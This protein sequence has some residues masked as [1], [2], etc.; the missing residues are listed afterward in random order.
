MVGHCQAISRSSLLARNMAGTL[1]SRYVVLLMAFSH[2]YRL[3]CTPT[4]MH[5]NT[6]MLVILVIYTYF[7]SPLALQLCALKK[8]TSCSSYEYKYALNEQKILHNLYSLKWQ[9]NHGRG[10]E[11][12]PHLLN[13]GEE[14]RLYVRRCSEHN[15][16]SHLFH[17]RQPMVLQNNQLVS[18]I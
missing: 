2:I 6:F 17:E 12:D 18:E 16:V 14:G 7:L 8:F 4:L 10:I 9:T 15:Q 11:C 13:Q 1:S 5:H 3:L